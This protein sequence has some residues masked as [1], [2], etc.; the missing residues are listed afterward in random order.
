MKDVVQNLTASGWRLCLVVDTDGRLVGIV[1]DGDIRRG[2]LAGK[3]LDA[4]VVDLMNQVFVS[5]ASSSG[6]GELEALARERE[7]SH[8]PI[9][10]DLGTPTGLFID[11]VDPPGSPLPNTVVVMAGG[12]GMRLRP[13][14]EKTP[15]PM[16]SVAG[17]PMVQHTIEALKAEGFRNFVLSLN[18]L[19]EQI[20]EYFGDG[21]AL[22][23]RVSYVK[24][25]EPLGT[26]GAL[27]LL[28]QNF[29]DPIIV[30]NA[31]VL[32]SA[33]VS[34]MLDYHNSHNAEVTVGVKVLETQIP[35]GVVDVV[36]SR[37]TGM[38]EKPVY[39][40][41]V[42]AGVYVL[43]PEVLKGVA[44]GVR[45]DMPDLVDGRLSG[46]RV[47]AFPLHESWRD[48][49]HIGDLEDARRDYESKGE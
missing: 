2:L 12:A 19:G 45:L 15:K 25:N 16:L 35:F 38:T 39:R 34:G 9:L 5:A 49:G 21:S 18:Y 20:E 41:F 27:S 11:Q 40:D 36:G 42:N 8:I 10:E 14:T 30:V 17:K 23:V 1:S 29:D 4:S 32:L 31:D 24:E 48:L 13:L 28:P 6:L 46:E 44:R 47:Y 7:V 3:G 43:E 26:A 22:G 37:I 33:K